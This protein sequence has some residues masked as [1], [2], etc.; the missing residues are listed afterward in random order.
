MGKIFYLMGK[1]ASGK[2]TIF[3]KI[4]EDE[5]ICLKNIVMY[6]TRPIRSGEVNGVDYYFVTEEEAAQLEQQGRIIEMRQYSTVHGIWKY[7]TV[8]DEQIDLQEHSYLM[9]GTLES[10]RKTK[11]YFGEEHLVPLYVTVPDGIRLERALE[12]EKRQPVPKYAEMCRR[13]L[14]DEEDFKEEN[15]KACHIAEEFEN[16]AADQCVERLV[17]RMLKE[18]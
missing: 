7:F 9:I 2:D 18:I 5:R 13:F 1:S 14:A 4:M 16:I 8:S 11:D 6:T 12:R 10:Y 17:Q 15:L 3:K